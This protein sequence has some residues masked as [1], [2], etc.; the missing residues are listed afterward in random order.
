M[1]AS[2]KTLAIVAR[3]PAPY[4]I[5]QHLRI[6][7]ELGDDVELW[8]LFLYEHNN[9]PWS[10]PL[11]AEIRPVVF[12]PGENVQ[13]SRGAFGW[14]HEWRKMG[15]VIRWLQQ[16]RVDAVITVGYSNPGHPRL[17]SWCRRAGIPNFLYGDSNIHGDATAGWRRKLKRLYI[18]WVLRNV[19]GV[20]PHSARG[21]QY[22]EAYGGADKPM[23]YV[24]QEPDY[25]SIFSVTAPQRGLNSASV[26]IVAISS[27]PADWPR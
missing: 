27:I 7:R 13:E 1:T 9:L 5:H 4:R 19:S 6:A 15:R 26:T 17:I 14:L 16:K 10:Q 3:V 22:F 8:S 18:S 2:L 11:P 21:R 12:G 23:F 25:A 24:P 20:M